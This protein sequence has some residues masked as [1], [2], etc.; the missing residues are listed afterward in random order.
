MEGR[1]EAPKEPHV[2][3]GAICMAEGAALA[4]PRSAG[5][6]DRAFGLA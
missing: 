6:G 3:A 2:D 1:G 5:R 4:P